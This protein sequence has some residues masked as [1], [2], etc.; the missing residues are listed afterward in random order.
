[1]EARA[2]LL[3]DRIVDGGRVLIDRDGEW[4]RLR[5]RRPALARYVLTAE[6]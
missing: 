2:P 5:E 3:L 4:D 6:R 1:V